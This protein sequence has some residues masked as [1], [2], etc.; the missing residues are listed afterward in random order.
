MNFKPTKKKFLISIGAVILWYALILVFSGNSLCL[1]A[2][3]PSTFD[4]NGCEKVFVFNILPEDCSCGCSCP[5]STPLSD[6][7]IQLITILFPGILVY[8]IW[9]LIERR[10]WLKITLV[11]LRLHPNW[12]GLLL[13]PFGQYLLDLLGA[14]ELLFSRF[15]EDLS[16]TRCQPTGQRSRGKLRFNGRVPFLLQLGVPGL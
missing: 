8:V 4:A 7:F 10:N 5:E 16:G 6:I 2:I 13:L 9:S 3:C 12:S 15:P 11:L 14:G 1:C